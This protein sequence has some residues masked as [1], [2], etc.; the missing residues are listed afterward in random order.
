MLTRTRDHLDVGVLPLW[1]AVFCGECEVI[2]SSRDGECVACKGR[3]LVSLARMLGSRLVTHSAQHFQKW[4]GGLFGITIT[5]ELQ[6]V[7]AKDLSTLVE[8][9]Q[10]SFHV[11]CKAS[12]RQTRPTAPALLPGTGSRI[13]GCGHLDRATFLLRLDDSHLL[14]QESRRVCYLRLQ[15][16]LSSSGQREP[17]M[18][19]PTLL[20]QGAQHILD[21]F[22]VDTDLHRWGLKL[23]W[24]G[25]KQFGSRLQ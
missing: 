22:G 17:Q 20:V 15:H 25:E 8:L 23:A 6:E 19:L 11:A 21:H 2:S 13:E 16:R 14:P 3:S 4:E 24:H 1:N 12:S 18:Q 5:V 10:A 9:E 7:H